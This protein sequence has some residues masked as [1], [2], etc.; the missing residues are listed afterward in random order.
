MSALLQF[1]NVDADPSGPVATWPHEGM[2][3]AIE[4]GYLS[5]WRRVANEVRE[6]P[7]G[8]A[9]STLAEVLEYAEESPVA[10][11]LGGIL[12]D[13]RQEADSSDREEVA[14]RVKTLVKESGLS[15]GEFARLYGTSRSRL[16]TWM[17]GRVT[18]SAAALLRMQRIAEDS[19]Q[20][21][22]SPAVHQSADDY[23]HVWTEERAFTEGSPMRVGDIT[24]SRDETHQ[25]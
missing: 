7:Y 10:T 18:P 11:L 13:A 22:R 24:W 23:D 8:P 5:D 2:Q 20:D 1:R 12:S 9:A 4:R 16:S 14:A 25:R 17:N 3:A 15:Q 19:A 6:R 21:S